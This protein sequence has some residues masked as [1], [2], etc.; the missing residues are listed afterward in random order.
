MVLGYIVFGKLPKEME[1]YAIRSYEQIL[2]FAGKNIEAKV[3]EYDHLTKLMYSYNSLAHGSLDQILEENKTSVVEDF[4]QN[5]VFS[6]TYIRSALL[7]DTEFSLINFYTRNASAINR[8]YDF[9]SLAQTNL[10]HTHKKQLAIL[11]THYDEYFVREQRR[12]ISFARNYLDIYA[13]PE[14]EEVLAT[15]IIDVDAKVLDDI[16][17][18]VKLDRGGNL[19]I[20]DTAGTLIYSTDSWQD[21]DYLVNPASLTRASTYQKHGNNYFFY[22]WIDGSDW[23]VVYE[24]PAQILFGFIYSNRTFALYAV[25]FLLGALIL[26]AV[27]FSK[28]LSQP[29]QHITGQIK[30]VESGD[31]DFEISIKTHDEIQEL[32]QAFNSMLKQLNLYINKVYRA[33]IQQR[34]AELESIKNQIKPHFLNNTL[35][36]IRMSAL[37]EQ[38]PR[39]QD[40]IFALSQQLTYTLNYK[41]TEVS[42]G[43]EL[44]MITNYIHIVN[45][46]YN[47]SIKLSIMVDTPLHQYSVLKLIIQP[48]VENAVIHGLKPKGGKGSIE[49]RA[50]VET[51][52]KK[53][54]VESSPNTPQALCIEI[55]DNGVGISEEVL[56]AMREKCARGISGSLKNKALAVAQTPAHNAMGMA[57]G[58]TPQAPAPMPNGHS[59]GLCNVYQRIHLRYGAPYGL[60]IS[61]KQHTGT[62]VT[63]TMPLKKKENPYES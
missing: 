58:Q 12:V 41:E 8:G 45:M 15:M 27:L 42:L 43:R 57:H 32:A 23:V 14:Q 36:I 24:V 9:S 6:D 48:I 20:M 31:L 34:E 16:L 10:L 46:R 30:R 54:S 38:A 21:A 35:E 28:H 5:T 60:E 17:H 11:P 26:L 2:Y 7:V 59:I 33:E 13:L 51:L 22:Q 40:M 19:F 4:L 61:S 63:L 47:E 44:E 62:L 52:T 3:A 39:T 29:I 49:I 56:Q 50:R 37:D 18:N 1:Q 25:L 53:S 55:L